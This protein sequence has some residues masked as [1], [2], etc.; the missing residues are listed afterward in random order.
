MEKPEA[1]S[2]YVK[3]ILEVAGGRD[4]LVIAATLARYQPEMIA[5]IVSSFG[6]GLL[7]A[8]KMR[9]VATPGG[10]AVVDPKRV[11]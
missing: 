8:P 2:P 7:A 11:N 3:A 10:G 5:E 9:P 1:V 6:A 4:F